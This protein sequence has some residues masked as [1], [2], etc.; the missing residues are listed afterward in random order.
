MRVRTHSGLSAIRVR[1]AGEHGAQGGLGGLHLPPRTRPT[2]YDRAQQTTFRE[3]L[4]DQADD[5]GSD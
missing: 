2:F 5:L 1:Q 3:L 4:S